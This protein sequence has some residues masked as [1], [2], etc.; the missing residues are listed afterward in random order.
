[1]HGVFTGLVGVEFHHHALPTLDGHGV[2]GPPH[3]ILVFG[4]LQNV[5]V[6]AVE[7]QNL[8]HAAMIYDGDVHGMTN[9]GVNMSCRV[10]QRVGKIQVVDGE[11]PGHVGFYQI[12]L[13]PFRQ[14]PSCRGVPLVQIPLKMRGRLATRPHHGLQ[15]EQIASLR[16][17]PNPMG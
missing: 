3:P 2:L 4:C 10:F 13:H 1:M 15:A 14:V 6:K 7:V 12:H 8:V 5:H 9:R 11:L 17:R 16:G